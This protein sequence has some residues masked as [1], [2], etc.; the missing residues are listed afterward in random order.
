LIRLP[1]HDDRFAAQFRAVEQFDRNEK[2]I[3]VDV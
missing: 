3:H 1:A 2:R